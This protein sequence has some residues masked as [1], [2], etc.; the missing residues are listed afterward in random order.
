MWYLQNW[1]LGVQSTLQEVN[2]ECLQFFGSRKRSATWKIRT[3]AST[4][5]LDLYS[6]I[7]ICKWRF[8]LT[9]SG[10]SWRP[11][12]G[13][14]TTYFNYSDCQLNEIP[15]SSQTSLHCAV[16]LNG[17]PICMLKHVNS[18]LMRANGKQLRPCDILQPEKGVTLAAV[19]AMNKLYRKQE[20]LRVKA[21]EVLATKLDQVRIFSPGSKVFL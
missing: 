18:V 16:N 10:L 14:L 6:R 8:A 21:E 4:S 19:N 20:A 12:S 15:F 13:A 17:S 3:H 1:A 7:T 9:I 5:N 11:V 2:M